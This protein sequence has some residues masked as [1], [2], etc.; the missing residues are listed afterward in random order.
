MTLAELAYVGMTLVVFLINLLHLRIYLRICSPEV[1]A[2]FY[3]VSKLLP[4]FRE[5][6][7][8]SEVSDKI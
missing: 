7:E 3:I 5:L 8:V 4:R 2:L 6:S 1:A